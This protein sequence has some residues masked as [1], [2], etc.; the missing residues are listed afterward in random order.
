[1]L[2]KIDLCS[3]ALLK[4]GENPIQSLSDDTVAAKLGRTL[5][6]FVIDTLLAMH[7]WKF[8]CRE[9]TILKDENGNLNVPSDVL[10]VIKTDARIIE[11][12]IISDSDSVKIIAIRRMLPDSFPSYFSSVV[13]T[14]LAM[15]F[16]IPLTSDQS[17]F[18]TL[19]AL[20]ESELQTAK[21]ID[22]TTSIN[23]A[24]ENFSLLDSRF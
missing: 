18:R 22:S 9:Y 15:E 20:Y 7:P 8:A 11:N 21:F 12:K 2:T 4:L 3:M 13:S 1:M 10:R 23:S 17:V 24:I 6:D 5:I 16:C 14:K 19:V